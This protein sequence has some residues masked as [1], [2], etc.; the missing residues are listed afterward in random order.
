MTTTLAKDPV[1]GMTV[2][3]ATAKAK[4]EH[5]RQTYYFCCTGCAQKRVHTRTTSLH[6][7]VRCAPKFAN[8]NRARALAAAWRWSRNFRKCSPRSSTPAPCTRR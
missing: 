1:C 4:A 8:R 5:A 2:D 6:M 3:P 7:S